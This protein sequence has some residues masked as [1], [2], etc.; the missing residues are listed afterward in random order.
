CH[1]L[2]GERQEADRYISLALRY[3]EQVRHA[4]TGGSIHMPPLALTLARRG[5]FEEA[6]ALTPYVP[7][8]TSA[9]PPLEVL[10]EIAALRGRWEEAPGL[11]TAAR[12]EAEVGELLSL[13]AFADRL[14]GRAAHAEGDVAAATELLARSAKGFAAIDAPWEEAWSRLL[15]AEVLAGSEGRRAG[16]E[17]AAALPALERLRRIRRP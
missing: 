11:V 4:R 10:C 1:E 2:R 8:S 5:R 6:L 16:R 12:G 15:L 9:S 17:L 7:Q 14:E 13:P 3:F